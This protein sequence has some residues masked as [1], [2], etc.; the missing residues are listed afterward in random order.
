[1]TPTD[2]TVENKLP[3]SA[4][5]YLIIVSIKK[6]IKELWGLMGIALITN[7]SSTISLFWKIILIILGIVLFAVIRGILMYR[8]FSYAVKNEELI[9]RKGAFRK[10]VLSI[11]LHKIQNISTTQS[12]WQQMLDIITLSVDTAGST[13]N[14]L[15][16]FLDIETSDGLKAYLLQSRTD[17]VSE[18]SDEERI[19]PAGTADTQPPLHIYQYDIRQL[20]ISALSRNHLKS[21]TILFAVFFTFFNQI[22]ER[23]QK[24]IINS[25]ASYL[26]HD[27]PVTYWIVVVLVIF[28]ISVVVNIIITCLRYYN[29]T[30]KLSSDKIAYHAGLIR[31]MDQVIS[32]DKIQVIEE[33]TVLLE[34]AL[35]VSSLRVH[36]F[37]VFGEKSRNEVQFFMPGFKY[38]SELT[39][40]IYPASDTEQFS[41]VHSLRSFLF[42]NFYFYAAI[43]AFVFTAL[44][45]YDIR[46]LILLALSL[47]IAGYGAYLRYQKSKAEIGNDFI[48]IYSGTFGKK[49]ST[50]KIR[51]IQNIILRQ[52]VFQQR[53]KTAS[54]II[55][56]RWRSLTIP[57]INESEA[58]R[59]LD[60]LLY[61]T[62]C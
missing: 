60:F 42:R 25:A 19:S 8:N 1:M 36:Q 3:L 33:T 41:E 35:K 4:V 51:N 58:K 11:P 57:F 7:N 15:E 2:F 32:L 29:L 55:S 18:T 26:P 47:I 62:E 23:Y 43:P 31:Q 22:G 59:V 12:F 37:V 53:S 24:D 28:S 49:L 44:S 48:R 61:K 27:M 50:V 5:I 13:K 14:E 52:S 34:K 17:T 9:V 46:S 39:G 54:L 45:F 38:A 40:R 16:I 56:T 30:V 20:L 21:I 10:T 6:A